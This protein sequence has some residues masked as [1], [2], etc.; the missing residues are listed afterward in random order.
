MLQRTVFSSITPGWYNEHRR[1]NERGGVLSADVARA[2]LLRVGLT[3]FGL[4]RQSS[5]L[6]SFVRFSYQFISVI[7]LFLYYFCTC[8]FNF[9]LYFSCLNGCVGWQLCSRL[10]AWNGLSLITYISMYARM[11]RCYNERRSRTSYDRS[12]IAHCMWNFNP[13]VIKV[14]C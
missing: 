3:R 6:L 13:T 5:S 9:V 8:I 10:W 1:Y 7:C 12:S 14:P 11:K 4:E 2:C